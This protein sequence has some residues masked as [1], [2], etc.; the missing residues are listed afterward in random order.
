VDQPCGLAVKPKIG[1]TIAFFLNQKN[2]EFLMQHRISKIKIKIRFTKVRPTIGQILASY[3]Y[4]VKLKKLLQKRSHRC[5]KTILPI[6]T[7]PPGQRGFGT[8]PGA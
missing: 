4:F 2:L 5:I 8:T 7:K 1:D 6:R 3:N